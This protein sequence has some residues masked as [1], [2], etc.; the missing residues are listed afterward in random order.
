MRIFQP[1]KC[2]FA[3]KD[4]NGYNANQITHVNFNMLIHFFHWRN[5]NHGQIQMP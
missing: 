4:F 5:Q 1:V 3:L 2:Q